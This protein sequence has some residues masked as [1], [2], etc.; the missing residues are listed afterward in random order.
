MKWVNNRKLVWSVLAISSLTVLYTL[1]SYSEP[2]A[3][4]TPTME[5]A[6]YLGLPSG[7]E[8]TLQD[9]RDGFLKK[10]PSGKLLAEKDLLRFEEDKDY[11]SIIREKNELI[12]TYWLK[13]SVVA[14]TGYRITIELER[15]SKVSKSHVV[16]ID[17][18]FGVETESGDTRTIR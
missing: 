16:S 3:C 6:W 7:Q 9:V 13:A 18:R 12:C 4:A 14:K 10:I 15:D 1:F 11:Y 17:S 2:C 8:L 5:L